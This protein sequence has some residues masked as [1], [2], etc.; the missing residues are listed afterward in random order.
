VITR[1]KCVDVETLTNPDHVGRNP[2]ENENKT[3][4]AE[5]RDSPASG[6]RE[7]IALQAQPVL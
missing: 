1:P 4:R 6:R 2:S 7:N 3:K 5:Y